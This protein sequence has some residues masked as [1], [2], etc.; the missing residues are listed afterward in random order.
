MEC[1]SWKAQQMFDLNS[2]LLDMSESTFSY[3]RDCL[4]AVRVSVLTSAD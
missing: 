3:F 1:S 4:L 2:L